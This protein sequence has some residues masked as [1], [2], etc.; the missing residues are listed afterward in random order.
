MQRIQTSDSGSNHGH[1]QGFLLHGSGSSTQHDLLLAALLLFGRAANEIDIDCGTSLRTRISKLC[2]DT[3]RDFVRSFE[4][5]F[6]PQNLERICVFLQ[7]KDR[8]LCA[9]ITT[10]YTMQRTAFELGWVDLWQDYRWAINLR[11]ASF[12]GSK[13]NSSQRRKG[14]SKTLNSDT[15]LRC[16]CRRQKQL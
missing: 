15:R 6:M 16:E 10:I 13:L 2:V 8:Q 14:F 11:C 1:P 3:R 12:C 5:I 7:P 4:K 9:Q